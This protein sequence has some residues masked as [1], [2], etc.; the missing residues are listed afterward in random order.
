MYKVIA[1]KK[2]LTW[3]SFIYQTHRF[4]THYEA[5]GL[6]KGASPQEIK[7]AYK[8]KSL[9]LHPDINQDDPTT[10]DRF[11]RVQ[12]AYQVL[13]K[14]GSRD[15]YDSQ[16]EVINIYNMRS[17]LLENT[18]ER[19]TKL[20]TK[21]QNHFGVKIDRED[22]IKQ[23]T[24]YE[25]KRHQS[26]KTNHIVHGWTSY[27]G[28][29]TALL[30]VVTAAI[31]V[32]ENKKKYAEVQ[33]SLSGKNTQMDERKKMFIKELNDKENR[34]IAQIFS[35]LTADKLHRRKERIEF[36]RWKYEENYRKQR[37]KAAIKKSKAY[38][39]EENKR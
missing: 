25:E 27:I 13:S 9:Q 21:F 16:L 4:L 3:N 15:D 12:E 6:N 32:N 18:E 17:Q 5:L 20:H 39:C 36:E 23:Y 24:A 31:L 2:Y 10:H 30:F 34:E 22:F 29:T 8:V 26:Q 35:K 28:A 11:I 1:V 19:Y 14:E 37:E 38:K 33:R 7:Q